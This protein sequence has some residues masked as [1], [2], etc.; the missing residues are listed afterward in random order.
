MS[1]QKANASEPSGQLKFREEGFNRAE[2]LAEVREHLSC[3]AG[4]LERLG[5]DCERIGWIVE[6]T[7]MYIDEAER[8]QA[9]RK[10][11]LSAETKNAQIQQ[12]KQAKV[13]N[14]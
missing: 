7:L 6:D 13:S 9:D 2:L 4:I 11:I 1:N 10:L 14:S 5:P 12:K 8:K 3:A